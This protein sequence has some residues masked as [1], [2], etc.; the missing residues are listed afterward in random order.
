MVLDE[1]MV[2]EKLQQRRTRQ[3]PVT[4]VR[5]RLRLLFRTVLQ[6]KDLVIRNTTIRAR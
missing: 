3:T 1:R 5:E 6:A 2:L 4:A